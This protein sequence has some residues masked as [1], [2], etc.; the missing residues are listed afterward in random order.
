MKWT[1]LLLIPLAALAVPH[2]IVAQA[3]PA[4]TITGAAHLGPFSFPVTGSCSAPQ[5]AAGPAG[6]AGPAG[7]PGVTV[8]LVT[9]T[10]GAAGLAAEPACGTVGALALDTTNTVLY[11]CITT[12]A[13]GAPG[14]AGV[15]VW[16]PI[17]VRL[18]QA[19][20]P[21]SSGDDTLGVQLQHARLYD[22]PRG[23]L[24]NRRERGNALRGFLLLR[25][26]AARD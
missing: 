20:Q 13:A 26:P 21:L 4:C 1:L 5:G 8:L 14:A 16:V 19:P 25:L 3:P 18:A 22:R 15:A 24:A 23:L 2:T 11:A 12:G 17:A 7:A 6:P 10:T 9:N